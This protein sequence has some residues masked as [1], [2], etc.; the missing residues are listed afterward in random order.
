MLSAVPEVPKRTHGF[1]IDSLLGRREKEDTHRVPSPVESEP[2]DGEYPINHELMS[3]IYDKHYIR[4]SCL[5]RD[6]C[7]S[8]YDGGGGTLHGRASPS[9]SSAASLPIH[10]SSSSL[11]NLY[12]E[13]HFLQFNDK[14]LG[15]F[16]GL[17]PPNYGANEHGITQ[18]PLSPH[19]LWLASQRESSNPFTWPMRLSSSLPRFNGK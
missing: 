2:S 15:G 16:P 13:G 8:F 4:H 5:D 3:R 7:L 9:A 19:S 17:S 1:T 11:P 10:P 14:Y 18:T 6:G 12:R